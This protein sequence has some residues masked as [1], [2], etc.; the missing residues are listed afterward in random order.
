MRLP[1]FLPMF[2]AVASERQRNV[3]TIARRGLRG[4][5]WNL[6]WSR[7]PWGY[8]VSNTGSGWLNRDVSWS[9]APLFPIRARGYTQL[10]FSTNFGHLRLDLGW[11]N[12]DRRGERSRPH[13][14]SSKLGQT[15][16]RNDSL[17]PAT[18]YRLRWGMPS[19]A[20]PGV[21]AESAKY[22][23]I[24]TWAGSAQDS[25]DATSTKYS[26]MPTMTGPFL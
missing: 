1:C 9:H 22:G 13:V 15:S 6:R 20:R 7:S 14:G 8:S 21:S 24:S 25:P 11:P 16:S 26:M 19:F 18:I 23:R 10:R 2:E 5:S 3:K 4:E 12:V 17:G